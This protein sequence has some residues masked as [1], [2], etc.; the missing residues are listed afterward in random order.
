[1]AMDEH[2]I[3]RGW[4]GMEVRSTSE[5]VPGPQRSSSQIRI[6]QCG[7]QY[8][9]QCGAPHSVGHSVG[10]SMGYSMGRLGFRED[11]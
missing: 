6:G 8:G 11:R 3:Q 7:V 1:M 4:G 9:A 5:M 2:A 10:C